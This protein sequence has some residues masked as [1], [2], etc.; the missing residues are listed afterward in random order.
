MAVSKNYNKLISVYLKESEYNKI[1][2]FIKTLPYEITP[3][4][5][6]RQS[7]LV[8]LDELQKNKKE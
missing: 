8:Y 4:V 7:I 3:S 1:I 5:F 2:D 6:M